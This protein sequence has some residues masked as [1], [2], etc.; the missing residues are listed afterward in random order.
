MTTS[1]QEIVEALRAS[2][3]ETE[4]LQRQNRELLAAAR[5]PIAIVAMACRYPG[6][7]STPEQL[8]DLVAAGRDATSEFPTDRGWPEDLYDPD[9]EAVGHSYVNRGGFLDDVAG[10]DAEFFGI[11]PREALAMDPQ[12]RL[13]LEVSYEALERTGMEPARLRG[14]RTGV[15]IGAS[16]SAYV[17]D[18]SR[19]PENVE[20]YALTGNL[21][22][23]LSGRVA[24]SFGFEGPAVTVDTACSS[25]LVALHLAVQALRQGEC[26]LALAGGVTVLASPTAFVEFSRQRGLARD[27]R[28]K[29]FSADADGFAAAEGIGVLALARLSDAQQAGHPILA[30]IR[31]TAT[32]QDGA[33]NGLTA[34]NGPSQQR[35]IRAAL[36]NAGLTVTDID[37]VEAHGTGTKLGDPIEAQALLSTYGQRPADRP[38]HL[39][40]LKSNLGHTQ[41]AAGVGS[42]IKMVLAARA[43]TLPPTLHADQPSPMIDWSA[44]AVSLL[45][46]PQ[47]WQRSADHVRRAGISSFGV[48]GTNAHVIIE[49]A[50]AVPPVPPGSAKDPLLTSTPVITWRLS[51]ATTAGLRAQAGQLLAFSE[52]DRRPDA[53]AIGQALFDRPALR[54]RLAITA[55]TRDE[56]HAGL[57]H[58]IA[59]GEADAN[60]TLGTALSRPKVAFVFPGQGWQWDGMTADLL[61]T[62]PVFAATVAEA[63]ALIEQ[64]TGWS[65]V[66]ILRQ[67][68]GAPDTGRVDVIQPV[69]F[70]VMVA[71]ARTWQAAGIQPDAVIGHSQGEIAAAHIAGALTLD[72]AVHLV[73]TRAAALTKL[74]PGAMISLT[75]TPDRAAKLLAE[76]PGL[77]IAAV[78]GPSTTIV[79]GDVPAA[80]ALLAHCAANNIHARRIPVTYASHSPHIDVLRDHLLDAL[81]HVTPRSATIPLIS[82]LTGARIDTTEMTGRYW[83]DNLRQPVA[84]HQAVTAALGTGHNTFVE[85]SAHPAL[86]QALDAY[87]QPI[88]THT[89]LRRNTH[90]TTTLHRNLTH[91]WTS[92]LVP[93]NP[94]PHHATVELPT[95]RFHRQRFWLD[96]THV[97]EAADAP[98]PLLTSVVEVAGDR[99][100]HVLS[101]RLCTRSQP[102]LGEHT[103][104]DSTLLPGAVFVELLVRAGDA[105]GLP[106]V[107]ELVVERPLLLDPVT[108]T[109]VQIVVDAADDAGYRRVAVHARRGDQAVWTRHVQATLSTQPDAT[110]PEPGMVVWP[111]VG[112]TPIDVDGLYDQL[113]ERTYHYGP[114]FRGLQKAW[115][116]GDDV[117]AEVAL[118]ADA[119]GFG[120]HPALLDAAAHAIPFG[121]FLP[122]DGVWLPFSWTGVTLY[123]SG[124]DRIR[125]RLSPGPGV[126]AVEIALADAAGQPVARIEAMHARR[127]DATALAGAAFSADDG[128]FTLDWIRVADHPQTVVGSPQNWAVVGQLAPAGLPGLPDAPTYP[129]LD[130]LIAAV[131]GGMP[132]PGHVLLPVTG[133][134]AAALDTDA[135]TVTDVACGVGGGVLAVVQRWLGCPA[136]TSSRLVLV[137]RGAVGVASGVDDLGASVVWG[138]LRTAQAEEPDR[139][140]LCDLDPTDEP[141]VDWS[142]LI[143][144]SRTEPQL[145]VRGDVLLAPRL[146]RAAR[147]GDRIAGTSGFGAGTGWR[148]GTT[149]GGSID[150]VDRIP[151]ATQP[152]R[153]GEVRIGVR[154][155]GLNFYD[156]AT[157]LGMVDTSDGMG[158]EGA[159]VIT[160]V[161]PGVTNRQVGD[162]VMG[163]FPGAFA[164]LATADAR[165]VTAIPDGWTYP[166]AASVPAVFL[167]AYYALRDLADLQPGEKVLI[168]AATGGVGMA[169]VQLATHLGA[170]VYATASPAKWP[171]LREMGI[172]AERIASSRSTDFTA[173]FP[174]MDVVLGSL[175]GDM[176]DASITLLT[177]GG[178]Y[179]E[180][181]KTDIRDASDYPGITYRAFDLKEA[182]PQRTGEM[183]GRL[184]DLFADGALTALPVTSWELA[185]LRHAL[186]HM[187]QA[188]HTG[189]NVIRIPV[190]VDPDG[191]TVI[192]G[193]TGTIGALVAARLVEQGHSRRLLL[194]SRQGDA[195]P[196][197]AELRERLTELGAEVTIAACDTTDPDQLIAALDGIPAAHPVTAVVH[198]TGA[199]RD[200]TIATLTQQQLTEVLTTKISGA[201]TLHHYTRH[202][203][204]GAYL[205]FSSAGGLLGSPGQA[206][207]TAANTFLDALATC[208][209]PAT[210]IAWGLW[211]QASAM[212]A[213]LSM[214]DVSRMGRTAISPMTTAHALHL[215]DHT[216]AMPHA[217]QLAA[218]LNTAQLP[219]HPLF[220][221]L[222][223]VATRH[224]PMAGVGA[225]DLGGQLAQLTAEQ[226][227]Q[228]VLQLVQ[229]HTA[230]V[231]AKPDPSTIG[232]HQGFLDQ[233][234]DSLTAIE[235]R[236]RL[237]TATGLRLP[238]TTIFDHPTPHA[239]TRHLLDEL[240]PD[241]GDGGMEAELHADLDRVEKWLASAEQDAVE[242]AVARMRTMLNALST[243]SDVTE[244]LAS[245]STDD[246]LRLI[247]REFM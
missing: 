38:L 110:S 65:V 160:E 152:L 136:L 191:T 73:V 114:S 221:Q 213:H 13:L 40:S 241:T 207:Y 36:A 216:H 49:E 123:A 154:A 47:P 151:A 212:T 82:T 89:T 56:L 46:E 45:T 61:D 50:P 124:A 81:D 102:W 79:S 10:F 48:S 64:R 233:G 4:R 201:V 129:G 26:S 173:T 149:G 74:Q 104:G 176:V 66:D 168:H 172:P 52:S 107:K 111:P 210:S 31:G 87:D 15:F 196:G 131:D 162:R 116:L 1:G 175:A 85:I 224:R 98:H 63:S 103:V 78:N 197:A 86:T 69:M 126:G 92:G 30:V 29:P 59:T 164:P 223:P 169:A 72:D 125:V 189:K 146:V 76:H 143:A 33:S 188:K 132:A 37:V 106:H 181:G 96:R 18:L 205:L 218:P 28:C 195:A 117:Y 58:F 140:V 231:L 246:L 215:F 137:T 166:Q 51:G 67:D 239:L 180:M 247:D 238:A 159:G 3:K 244:V 220:A 170:T 134:G 234:L 177:P 90:N 185:D 43:E 208:R 133:I 186:R 19:V 108:P 118:P 211:S 93:A 161:G 5:E 75:T 80:E 34:P 109:D 171:V 41:A 179:L 174:V 225:T 147:A 214:S 22:S 232:A 226:Q 155:A 119:A 144:A 184:V 101:G 243:P 178:R 115:R 25:S 139:F 12:Q 42:L 8:W 16:T 100:T 187:S 156:V 20:G 84:F 68:P 24:Y 148:V 235:L 60:S 121:E 227:H 120:L 94:H 202:L 138:M 242:R 71:L 206:N 183:L 130:D 35:V 240:A 6:G 83:Y 44:G 153:P 53:A 237:N 97:A 141:G 194:L 182:G 142:R 54:H 9:P 62:C 17:P 167:T 245:G 135:G 11:S 7:V 165:M 150:S 200:A 32:N 158:A 192:T 217:L 204:L 39:G 230:T 77:H 219:D 113:A 163:T 88:V 236:N 2:V 21:A 222:R 95:Y 209:R 128:L 55:A 91:G 193:G 112:A 229:S 27:G 14:S 57:E 105:V 122:A 190:P 145:A 199:L 127:V 203:E 70:T 99:G 23:V 157:A 198:S 228:H